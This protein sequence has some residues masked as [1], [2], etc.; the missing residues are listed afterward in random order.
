MVETVM[1]ELARSGISVEKMASLYEDHLT[2]D[3]AIRPQLATPRQQFE[4]LARSVR[5]LIT[6]RWRATA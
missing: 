1:S 3:H 6:E 2:V 5:D 4:A